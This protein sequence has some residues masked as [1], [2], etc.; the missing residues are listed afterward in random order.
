[1]NLKT[2]NRVKVMPKTK[3]RCCFTVLV[4]TVLLC[5][6]ACSNRL[7]IASYEGDMSAVEELIDRGYDVNTY[8]K[9][10]WTPLLWACHYS[11]YDIVHILL[12]KGANPNLSSRSDYGY[13][14]E[15]SSPLMLAV[16]HGEVMSVKD[17]LSFSADKTIRNSQGK[18]VIDYAKMGGSEKIFN[19]LKD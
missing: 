3:T 7:S 14:P 12:E 16:Y 18:T 9:W 15:G 19:L 5:Q 13:I 1:M 8:D 11:R 10:G 2:I 17:L 4:I 6:G